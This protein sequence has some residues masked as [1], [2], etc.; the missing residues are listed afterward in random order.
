MANVLLL[1]DNTDLLNVVQEAIALSG[2][3]VHTARTGKEGL[4]LLSA[5]NFQPDT[6]ICDIMM[7]DMDGLTFL[8]HIRQ[9]PRYRDVFFIVVS[10]NGG[11]RDSMI[12]AG[13]DEYLA[14][15]FS[16]ITLNMLIE[17]RGSR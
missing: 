12:A 2:H 16:I 15:P 9:T 17:T 3:E 5:G 7:P 11:D 13:A 6:I 4:D 8:R 14:K 10:G 1:E